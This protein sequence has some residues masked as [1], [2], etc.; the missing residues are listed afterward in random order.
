MNK[1]IK[2]Y[3]VK[4]GF[5]KTKRE[6]ELSDKK[7]TYGNCIEIA[8]GRIEN[9]IKNN[10]NTTKWTKECAEEFTKRKELDYSYNI[11][12]S[13]KGKYLKL[14]ENEIQ[15]NEHLVRTLK[16]SAFNIYNCVALFSSNLTRM[17]GLDDFNEPT[18]EIVILECKDSDRNILRQVIQNGI[19][20]DG[21]KYRF[22]TA[23][24]GQTRLEKIQVI[25]EELWKKYERVI[26]SGLT[27]EAI[28]NSPEG[29]MNI[30]KFLAYLSL[31]CS[32]TDE[33]KDFD[34]DRCI[35]VDD[36]NTKVGGWVDY[37]NKNT[38]KITRQMMKVPI[39]HADGAGMVLP[40][41]S[42]KNFMVRIPW[43]KGLLTSVDFIKFCKAERKVNNEADRYKIKDI[44][45]KEY[46]LIKDNIQILFT[47]S[48]FK[49][50]KYYNSWEQY[51]D[52]FKKY[53]CK[54]N[55]CNEEEEV[56]RQA[57][58]N[59]QM[60]QTLTD[61]TGEEIKY[62]TESSI[63]YIRKAHTDRA[64][65]QDILGA[66][67]DNKHR[68]YLQEALRI[69]PEMLQES[70]IKERLEDSIEKKAKEVR[71]G[72]IND[73]KAS[74]T[75]I[76]PDIYA[77]LDWLFN[78]TKEPK[79][80]LENGEVSC[81]LYK[82][83]KNLVVN[84][85]PHLFKEHGCRKNIINKDTKKWFTT[86]AVY[87]STHDLISKLLQLDVDGDHAL[88]ISEPKF[89]EIAERNMENV[90][91]LYYEMG[92]AKPIQINSIN[93]YESLTTA[94]DAGNIGKFSNAL[95][96]IWNSE[97][98]KVYVKEMKIICALN[99]WSIDCA[100]TLEMPVP[101]KDIE[102]LLENRFKK[103]PYFFKYAKGK[104]STQVYKKND[105]T[106]NKLCNAVDT[107]KNTNYNFGA[108]FGKFDHRILLNN[109]K[110]KVS[111]INEQ[112]KNKYLELKNIKINTKDNDVKRAFYDT[113]HYEFKRYCKMINMDIVEA[114]DMIIKYVY[115][116]RKD[117]N[118]TVL[119]NI[120][121]DLIINNMV[122][123]IKKSLDDGYVMCSDC[124]TRIKNTNGKVKRCKDCAIRENI[125]K[126][127]DKKSA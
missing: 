122:N 3:S 77:W 86:N 68:S 71:S 54:A 10:F 67:M 39:D 12:K 42:K 79:G 14:L 7:Y 15:N 96:N 25:K 8:K 110:M 126:T 72:K 118:K 123:N 31:N 97:K 50:W 44:Y 26:M 76:L 101:P 17:F 93:I 34:I 28:N 64:F 80:L 29:G 20:I 58:L 51:K 84:R 74:N 41:V 89:Y 57:K 83:V 62:F 30:N 112:I 116:K 81:K 99:N 108:G 6:K 61:V 117:M 52:Y 38:F 82:D 121:G 27:I 106:V 109:T 105:S 53:N 66:T 70:Y 91:P 114:T 2:I 23:S 100:K 56:F 47:K 11:Y 19:F 119:W 125:R 111:D 78:G 115:V 113:L 103:V 37:V 49:M 98:A 87:I 36:F 35:V 22:F 73:I 45:G 104:K 85:S 59:Y 46:D 95:T 43:M 69:H 5:V 124:G 32:A 4:L 40:G 92:K 90:Y 16:S 13:Y 75:F 55:K 9:T 120:L 102:D 65:M 60:W 88:V 107:M 127:K 48:Q 24:A 1:Q 94:Y 18:K 21:N 63:D 33:W